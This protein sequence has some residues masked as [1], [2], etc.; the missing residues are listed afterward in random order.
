M[1]SMT[2]TGTVPFDQR[3]KF[4][5]VVLLVLKCRSVNYSY[6]ISRRREPADEMA[7]EA[8]AAFDRPFS[9]T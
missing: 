4:L 8:V 2:M 9:T 6:G 1:K 5:M 3:H 7:N